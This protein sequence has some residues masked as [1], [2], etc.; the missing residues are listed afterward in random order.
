MLDCV[1]A[2]V[3]G[4]VSLVPVLNG[5]ETTL[6]DFLSFFPFN[7]G[8]NLDTLLAILADSPRMDQA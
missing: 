2:S 3:K 8:N 1:V 7:T 5:Q 6:K 4:I